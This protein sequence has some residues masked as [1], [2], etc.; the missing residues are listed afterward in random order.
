MTTEMSL[1]QLEGRVSL[2]KAVVKVMSKTDNKVKNLKCYNICT[3]QR[4]SRNKS[5]ST[6]FYDNGSLENSSLYLNLISHA[7]SF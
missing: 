4:D 6:G 3:P 1:S 5:D 2:A 7:L